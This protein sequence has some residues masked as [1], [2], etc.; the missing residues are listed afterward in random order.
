MQRPFGFGLIRK[1]RG[2]QCSFAVITNEGTDFRLTRFNPFNASL[3]NRFGRYTAGAYFA[4]HLGKAHVI[5]CLRH[6]I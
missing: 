4:S 1:P 6:G 2:R 3:H 5:E